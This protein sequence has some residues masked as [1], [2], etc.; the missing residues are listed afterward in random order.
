[1]TANSSTSDVVC[2][3]S[4]IESANERNIPRRVPSSAEKVTEKKQN[5]SK[6]VVCESTIE[7]ANRR[8]F[9]RKAALGA[10]AVA[11]G[12][13]IVE[14]A[15]AGD[16]LLPKTAASSAS[17]CKTFSQCNFIAWGDVIVDAKNKNN[18]TL[19]K[20][21]IGCNFDY[22]VANH[23][24][25]FGSVVCCP[26]CPDQGSC[27]HVHSGEGIASARTCG[28]PNPLGLDFYTNYTKKMSI[29]RGGVCVY[30]PLKANGYPCKSNASAYITLET[31]CNPYAQWFLTASGGGNGFGVAPG[32]FYIGQG[33]GK[34][35]A[36]LTINKC[37]Q[38][39]IGT[40]TP[41]STLEVNG[42]TTLDSTLYVKCGAVGIGNCFG[43]GPPMSM[44]CVESGALAGV[45]AFSQ[46]SVGV[47][48]SSRKSVGVYGFSNCCF[49]VQGYSCGPA[50]VYGSSC[51]D[52]GVWGCSSFSVG[53]LGSAYNAGAIPI[54]TRG[55]PG[56]TAPL[57]EW[58]KSC[59]SSLSVVNKCGWI[60]VG[61]TTVPTTLT[62]GGS[63][64]AKTV[65][66]T[67]SSTKTIYKMG[68]TDFAVLVNAANG[69]FTVTLP[70]AKTAAGMIVFIKRMDA[71]SN[72]VMVEGS[73][74]GTKQDTIQG[75]TSVSLSSLYSSLTLLSN[76]A[77]APGTWLVISNAT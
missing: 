50:G 22:D 45:H 55:A 19:S 59:G 41:S 39:G 27:R 35:N 17:C 52:I 47:G 49:G 1:M 2:P 54:A 40:S 16:R 64:S 76:G 68:A 60:G 5:P 65:T 70:P 15:I 28:A 48:G 73:G 13:T 71:S 77:K 32:G 51:C 36:S 8:N 53:V 72:T 66:E 11:L 69:A 67:A 12:G 18:G 58:Q 7:S 20:S 6:K 33:N 38:V 9:I 23:A 26:Q 75:N 30:V 63:L 74:T 24:L 14:S 42:T 10:T 44:L 29:T 46:C 43:F 37:C 61:A 62:V 21:V 31:G 25:T 4:T 3:E 56:Q 57:Q 34:E